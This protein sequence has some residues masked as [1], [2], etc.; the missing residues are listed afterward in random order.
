MGSWVGLLASCEV[1][2]FSKALVAGGVWQIVLF[3][4]CFLHTTFHF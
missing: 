3:G 1:S 2:R 4:G